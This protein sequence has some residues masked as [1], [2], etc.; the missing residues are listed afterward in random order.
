MKSIFSRLPC[1]RSGTALLVVG[2]TSMISCY[3]TTSVI[4]LAL[5]LAVYY[6][7]L[8]LLLLHVWVCCLL[9]DEAVDI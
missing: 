2:I 5:L 9:M 6:K 7:S 4:I 8:R 3:L 1:L